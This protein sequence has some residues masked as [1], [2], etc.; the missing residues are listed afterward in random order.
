MGDSIKVMLIDDDEMTNMIHKAII[1]RLDP[2]IEVWTY[3]QAIEALDYLRTHP[4]QWPGFIFL[5]INMPEMNGWQFLDEYCELEGRT[6][7]FMLTSSIDPKDMIRSQQYPVVNGFIS[8]PLTMEI[9]RNQLGMV[10]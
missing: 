3:L 7:L 2:R 5:D 1:R 9:L 8:K 10:W 4:C 6:Q